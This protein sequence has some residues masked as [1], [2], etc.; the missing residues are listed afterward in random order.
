MKQ[1]QFLLLALCLVGIANATINETFFGYGFVDLK[2]ETNL[3]IMGI[4]VA[5]NHEPI[6]CVN[7]ITFLANAS[8]DGALIPHNYINMPFNGSSTSSDTILQTVCFKNFTCF[9]HFMNGSVYRTISSTNKDTT[10]L[11]FS[12]VTTMMTYKAS[13][14]VYDRTTANASTEARTYSIL[15]NVLTKENETKDSTDWWIYLLYLALFVYIIWIIINV[16]GGDKLPK[17]EGEGI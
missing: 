12:G 11:K 5:A 8:L 15:G 13:C 16:F 10:N 2:E 17:K 4:G 7:Q 6:L 9:L 3:T 1:T 14:T